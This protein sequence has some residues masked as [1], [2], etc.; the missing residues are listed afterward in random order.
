MKRQQFEELALPHLDAVYRMAVHLTR[1]THE[2][3]DLAQE[4]FVRAF[5]AASRFREV[6]AGIRPWLFKILRN[7]FYTR[8]AKASRTPVAVAD[9]S[10]TVN[11]SP[12]PGEAEPAWDLAALD[13]EQVDDR[14]KAAVDGLRPEYR[15]V[16][17]LWGVEGMRYR[18]IAEVEQVPIGTVMSRLFRT[19]RILMKQLTGCS[20]PRA[21]QVEAPDAQA[22]PARKKHEGAVERDAA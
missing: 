4:T 1:D 2:A 21:R 22:A 15:T 11:E 17:L 9:L 5:K 12:G 7:A 20:P 10:G 13:W 16:L 6:G 18:E 3:A 14:L 19:R 8:S